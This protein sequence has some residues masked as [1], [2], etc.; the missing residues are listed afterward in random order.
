MAHWSCGDSMEL[1]ELI[2]DVVAYWIRDDFIGPGFVHWRC[3]QFSRCDSSLKVRW[4]FRDV[5]DH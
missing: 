1:W 2:R 4:R 3:N 5:V